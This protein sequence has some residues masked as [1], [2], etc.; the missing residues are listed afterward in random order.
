MSLVRR[1]GCQVS[2]S[3][4]ASGFVF[5][6]ALT[7]EPG[8]L[9]AAVW[10]HGFFQTAGLLLLYLLT[11]ISGSSSKHSR[12]GIISLKQCIR[13]SGSF[14]WKVMPTEQS[15]VPRKCRPPTGQTRGCR[16]WHGGREDV[17][18]IA[19]AAPVLRD[20]VSL[21]GCTSVFTLDSRFKRQLMVPAIV[22]IVL[23]GL[24]GNSELATRKQLT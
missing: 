4:P 19:T 22:E 16:D 21:W 1:S 5:L 2:G 7:L 15:A 20:G 18:P 6:V 9:C 23:I 12:C 3:H 11:V 24:W 13:R 17:A 14:A 8:P 10:E